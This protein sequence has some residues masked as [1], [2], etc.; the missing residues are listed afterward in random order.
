MVAFLK[1]TNNVH[2]R[3]KRQI[4]SKTKRVKKSDYSSIMMRNS[5][6]LYKL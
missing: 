4:K 2:V 5:H 6:G 3:T 1:A